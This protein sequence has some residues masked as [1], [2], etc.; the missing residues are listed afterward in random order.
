MPKPLLGFTIAGYKSFGADEQCFFPLSK[1]NIIVGQN[2]SGKSNVL[3]FVY[4]V[5]SKFNPSPGKENEA[6]G[7]CPIDPEDRNITFDKAPLK[8]SL[9]SKIDETIHKHKQSGQKI[10]ETN[11]SVSF[12][13][14]QIRDQTDDNIAWITYTSDVNFRKMTLEKT[15]NKFKS[16][17][18]TIEKINFAF[19]A[20]R[21]QTQ[22]QSNDIRYSANEAIKAS[23]V[24]EFDMPA[25]SFI[26]AVRDISDQPE[27]ENDHSGAGLIQAL[28]RLQNPSIG[29]RYLRND[30]DELTSF[31][32][33]VLGNES[34]RIEVPSAQDDIYVEMDDK[35]LP[36][37]SLGTGVSEVLILALKCTVLKGHV[38]CIEEPE[39]HLHPTLQRKLIK[40]LNNNTDNQ[41]FITTHS[42]HILDN[43]NNSIFHVWLEN[44]V[45]QSKLIV[46]D[47]DQFNLCKELGYAASD[48]IQANC[49]IWVE[50]P[51][52]RVYLRKWLQTVSA[53]LTEGV[54]YTIMFYGGRLLS[55]LSVDDTSLD[56][57]IE[58]NRINQNSAILIDSDRVKK[59]Q[60]INKT[61]QR[62]VDEFRKSLR[63]V[64]VTEGREIEN[65]IDYQYIN[66][67]LREK[68]GTPA[69]TT[70][71]QK[72]DQ[73]TLVVNQSGKTYT[74]DKIELAR[75][76]PGDFELYETLD[77]RKN[78]KLLVE[79]I[80][81]C[82]K[83]LET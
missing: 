8:F 31:S 70:R 79:Y 58:I 29:E 37:R 52:D 62:I 18:G 32:R 17:R 12:F 4:Y 82:N 25:V 67:T 80:R 27:N 10:D 56:E 75:T 15:L 47:S 39:T 48:I 42:S 45:S 36:I 77:L 73:L 16:D 35:L 66:K 72:Y 78:L 50:G 57:F 6:V 9:P 21:P 11:Q 20:F 53:D 24:W 69:Y 81:S 63:F 22:I 41:Y 33:D 19:R 55:H 34:V 68:G 44:G 2:N 7:D 23:R 71:D 14:D 65:Y 76:I 1:I 40:Y 64:W 30:F 46:N 74:C 28:A 54:H 51:S 43:E 49:L 26:P 5:I 83:M 60:K 59:H 38:L 3:R 61:K 13:F